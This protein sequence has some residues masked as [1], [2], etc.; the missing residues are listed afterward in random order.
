[1][2]W[3]RK[4]IVVGLAAFGA[5]RLYELARTRAQIAAPPVNDAL[6]TVRETAVK[7]R[8]DVA[9]AQSDIVDELKPAL[10]PEGT[11]ATASEPRMA[12]SDGHGNPAERTG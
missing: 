8:D 11:G 10:A 2:R 5:Y 7:V 4:L 12:V 9:D 3:I 6:D 1:M